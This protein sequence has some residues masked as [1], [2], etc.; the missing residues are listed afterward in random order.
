MPNSC[1]DVYRRLQV[2]LDEKMH[3]GFPSTK[4]G[5]EIRILKFLFTPKEAQIATGLSASYETVQQIHPRLKETGITIR[6]LERALYRM[7][8][9]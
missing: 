8:S 2:H 5:V 6:E 1:D 3:I 4:S 9:K 7:A